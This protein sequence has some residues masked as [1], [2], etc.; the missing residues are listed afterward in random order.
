M[1]E[2]VKQA[3]LLAALFSPLV[4]AAQGP[5]CW[6]KVPPSEKYAKR[7][8]V[9]GSPSGE[10]LSA[11]GLVVS[12]RLV[13]GDSFLNVEVSITNCS[14]APV[15]VDPRS[16]SLFIEAP[17]GD[18]KLASLDPTHYVRFPK[19]G[20]TY[21]PLAPENLAYGRIGTYQLFFERDARAQPIDKM[22]SNYSLG[23]NVLLDRW[24]FN[25][26]FPRKKG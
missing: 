18:V 22:H 26:E 10:T 25:F 19:T 5:P 14:A 6:D 17:Q 13:D 8:I 16:F 23:L 7:H 1:M 24:Q 4:V 21:P 3:V 9:N 11:D 12:T 2:P 20:K 15:T